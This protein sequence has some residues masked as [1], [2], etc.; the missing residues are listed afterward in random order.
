MSTSDDWDSESE[1]LRMNT[2]YSSSGDSDSLESQD[3][4]DTSLPLI[5]HRWILETHQ[6]LAELVKAFPNV[7]HE[8][9]KALSSKSAR[10]AKSTL[11]SYK[12]ALV[13]KT[14]SGK[15]TLINCLLEQSSPILPSSAA[16]LLIFLQGRLRHLLGVIRED[17]SEESHAASAKE[18]LMKDQDFKS[19]TKAKL[20]KQMM[21]VDSV[22]NKLGTSY[23]IPSSNDFKFQLEQFLS[24]TGNPNTGSL[25]PL[26]QRVEIRG[27]FPVLA[28]G[29]VLVDLPGH[30]DTDETR[31]NSAAEYIKTADGVILGTLVCGFRCNLLNL[32]QSLMLNQMLID[33]RSV[34]DSV[35]LVATGTDNSFDENEITMGESD[36][37]KVDSLNKVLKHLR[38]STPLPKPKKPKSKGRPRSERQRDV[39]GQ[40]QEKEREKCLVLAP[41]NPT[42]ELPVFCVGSHDF[43]ALLT[44]NRHPLTFFSKDVT[45]VVSLKN[46]IQDAGESRRIKCTTNVLGRAD[47]FS[48]SVHLYFSEERYPGQLAPD[49]K[50]K[51]LEVLTNLEKSNLEELK[52]LLAGIK[53]VLLGIDQGLAKAV[54]KRRKQAKDAAPLALRKLEGIHWN[55]YKA[56]MVRNGVYFEYDAN[57]ELTRNILPDIQSTWSRGLNYRI[58]LDTK[59]AIRRIK[60]STFKAIDDIA[61]IFAGRGTLFEQMTSSTRRSLAVENIFSDLLENSLTS[62]SDAQRDASRSIKTVVQQQMTP[63]YQTAAQVSGPGSFGRMK[64]SNLQF[65]E[66]NGP[67]VFDPINSH[68]EALLNAAVK[69]IENDIKTELRDLKDEVNLSEDHLDLKKAILK[70]TLENRPH[71]AAK[72]VDLENRR[73][74]LDIYASDK[75]VE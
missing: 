13:G 68:I 40:I 3:S 44:G 69:T 21:D 32:A 18:K 48:E 71:F 45:G 16:N 56:L 30:G 19:S 43:L 35:V 25:W 15:S 63:Q 47:A 34:E 50:K 51:A 33:G 53:R 74:A 49:D 58:P 41:E 54:D 17:D 72:K 39:E 60:Q 61:E 66:Q 59:Q 14:G 73:A 22:R 36:Q 11:P 38:K 29:I 70:M 10:V 27:R 42:P 20:V 62:I 9:N 24:S 64:V 31:N 57:R 12:F 6:P 52:N 55:S 28:T 5:I 67:H 1:N 26:V 65:V 8:Q 23:E 75:M 7:S 2:G 46:H 4:H 37:E